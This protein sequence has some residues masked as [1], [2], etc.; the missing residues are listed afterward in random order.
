MKKKI[1][2][3]SL[4]MTTQGAFVGEMKQFVEV[5]TSWYSE[6]GGQVFILT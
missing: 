1:S 3:L 5:T 6:G 4:E 2:L